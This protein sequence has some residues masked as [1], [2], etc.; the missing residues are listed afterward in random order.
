MIQAIVL[1]K[2]ERTSIPQTAQALLEIEGVTEVYSVTGEYDLVVMIRVK[3][4]ER[5]A[6]VVTERLAGV[7]SILNTSTMVAFKIYSRADLE[8]SW[9]IG[10]D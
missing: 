10:V 2:V 4:Y 9:Q 6:E 8:Q 7:K 1:V 3:E 5:L